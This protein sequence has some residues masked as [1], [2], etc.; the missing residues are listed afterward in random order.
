[1][2]ILP[3]FKT[4]FSFR[5]HLFERINMTTKTRI[6]TFASVGP[7]FNLDDFI[8]H[9][10]AVT[11]R[12]ITSM[13]ADTC[14]KKAELSIPEWRLL[15]TL[16]RLGTASPTSI[17]QRADMD[18]VMTSRASASL[19]ARGYL[20]VTKDTRDGRVRQLSLT[21]KG[22][23]LHNAVV[24]LSAEFRNDLGAV[25][26]KQDTSKLGKSLSQIRT[27]AQPASEATNSDEAD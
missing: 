20:T 3:I 10:L 24:K 11:A 22:V 18:K 15:A 25:L 27:Y 4:S 6:E 17:G 8:P 14:L 12:A 9:R 5:R 21:K 2:P 23:A 16:G 26:S 19:A 7:A 1:M 13:F